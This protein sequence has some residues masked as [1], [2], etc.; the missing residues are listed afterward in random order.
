MRFQIHHAIGRFGVRYRL[1]CDAWPA[2]TEE[3]FVTPAQAR[4]YAEL[5]AAGPELVEEFELPVLDVGD[6]GVLQP[7]SDSP[8]G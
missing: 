3:W 7:D 5:Y 2:D 4:R 6:G 1:T 8:Q